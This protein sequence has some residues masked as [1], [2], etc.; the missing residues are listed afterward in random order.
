MWGVLTT[1]E[2]NGLSSL[3]RHG[4]ISLTHNRAPE[5]AFCLTWLRAA[6]KAQAG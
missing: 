3:F 5:A 4:L 2:K 1:R 6:G